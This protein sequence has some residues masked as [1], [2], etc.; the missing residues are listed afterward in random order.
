MKIC[1]VG[2]GYIGLPT[3]ALFAKN[4][5]EVLGVDVNEEIVDKLNQGIAHIEEPGITEAIE[6][7]VKKGHYHAS[8]KPEEA[9]TF[10]ITV[11]T[12]Y[13][14]EDLS[15]DLSYVISACQ[16]ILPV[17]KKGNVV[18][19]ESTIAPMST[20]E[21]IKPIFENEG[22]VIGEEIGEEGGEVRAEQGGEPQDSRG[23]TTGGGQC[24][25][26]E[27]VRRV[28]A[29]E[30]SPAEEMPGNSKREHQVHHG[31][32]TAQGSYCRT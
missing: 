31:E 30:R 6:N 16:S 27:E 9:D 11:P 29:E 22:Y 2:Q 8:L 32:R 23:G 10:I 20:D 13:V 18:I 25:N 17:L 28:S 24:Q 5:C 1:I 26:L 19:I 4:G 15:C 7:A 21:I 14:K 12:P 3:A